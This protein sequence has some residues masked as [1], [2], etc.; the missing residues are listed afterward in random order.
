MKKIII[1]GIWSSL[2]IILAS[3][4]VA[5]TIKADIGTG[6]INAVSLSLSWV[7]TIPVGT[8]LMAINI[9]CVVI[10]LC[11]QRTQFHWRNWLQIGVSVILGIVVNV[12]VYHLLAQI[13][14]THYIFKIML[15]LCGML[16][17]CFSVAMMMRLNLIGF[18]VESAAAVIANCTRFSFK[19]I[20]QGIDFIAITLS[21]LLTV[22]FSLN[23]AIREATILNF[24]LFAHTIQFFLTLLEKYNVFEQIRIK[25]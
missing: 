16:L 22:I 12:V 13:V 1:N 24:L 18:P 9:L 10:Q 20:R 15:F 19:Q 4:G 11:I 2:F 14:L 23:F 7:T 5:L 3:V 8:I 6:S 17:S 21:L 25:E